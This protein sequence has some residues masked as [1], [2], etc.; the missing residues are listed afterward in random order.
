MPS[1]NAWMVTKYEAGVSLTAE[2][3][4]YYYAVDTEG[5]QLPYIDG[6]DWTVH[7]G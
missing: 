4:P 1:L 5:N 2:R 7:Q 6:Q 3:N